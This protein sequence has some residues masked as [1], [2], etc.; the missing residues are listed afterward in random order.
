MHLDPEPLAI[1]ASDVE[2]LDALAE[3][4]TPPL[5][6]AVATL[7]GDLSLLRDDLRP[8]AAQ[9]FDP[10]AGISPEQAASARQLAADALARYRDSGCVVAAP[11][12][13]VAVRTMLEFL[14][15]APVADDYIELMTE[16]LAIDGVDRR[17]PE[18]NHATVAPDREFQVAIIGAGMSG[19]ATAHRL[20]QAGVPYVILEKNADVGG[21]WL[22]NRYPGCRTLLISL[23]LPY[24]SRSP[25][26]TADSTACISTGR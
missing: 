2:I 7:T 13:T 19:I 18:W 17:A 8:S 11:P 10:T 1:T 21:T 6:A 23:P 15:G 16:E 14:A 25:T 9:S 12:D 3:I 26:S 24:S 22:E 5:L 20:A 4:D